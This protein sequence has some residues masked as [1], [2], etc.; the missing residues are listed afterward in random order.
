M[1]D[2]LILEAAVYVAM[3]QL[4]IAI[5]S[6]DQEAIK[7]ANDELGE[8]KQKLRDYMRKAVRLW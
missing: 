8:A 1:T 2:K 3:G 5:N 7:K 6:D 4:T